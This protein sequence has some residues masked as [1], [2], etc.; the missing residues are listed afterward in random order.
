MTLTLAKQFSNAM[1]RAKNEN[2]RMAATDDPLKGWKIHRQ[3]MATTEK[4][5]ALTKKVKE[6]KKKRATMTAAVT[7]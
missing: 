7:A 1:R 4:I 5:V 6:L 2:A 3:K